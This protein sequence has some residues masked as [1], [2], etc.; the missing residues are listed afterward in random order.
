MPTRAS[1]TRAH[2]TFQKIFRQIF[3]KRRQKPDWRLGRG[4]RED[5][6][7]DR[8]HPRPAGFLCPVFIPENDRYSL[9]VILAS[10]AT[11]YHYPL[12]IAIEQ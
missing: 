11:T 7:A 4:R 5:S 9:A 8:R 3:R 1:L 6:C 2:G 12:Q 10:L